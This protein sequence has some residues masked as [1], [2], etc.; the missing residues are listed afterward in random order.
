MNKKLVIVVS[1]DWFFLSHRLPLA[2]E[3][4]KRG[5]DVVVAAVEEGNKGE[6]IRNLGMTFYPLPTTRSG[7]TLW[8]EIR[9]MFYLLWVYL[10]ERPDIVHHVAMKPVT[11]GSIVA[12]ICGVK[13]V[14]NAL[15]GMGFLFI[16]KEKTTWIHRLLRLGFR[17]GF[18]NR[19]IHFI[20]QNEDDF[21]LV[22][23]IGVLDPKQLYMIKGSGVNLEKYPYSVEPPAEKLKILL[24][25]RMLWDKGVGEFVRAAEQL[26]P[27]YGHMAEFVLCGGYDEGYRLRIEEEELQKWHDQGKINWIGYQ[28]DMPHVLAQAHIVVLPSYRE[29]L[30]KSLIEACSIGRPIVTTDVPGCRAVVDDGVNGYL[31]PCRNRQLLAEAIEKLILD[32]NLRIRMGK[33]S[34]DKAEHLFSLTQVVDQTFTIYEEEDPQIKFAGLNPAI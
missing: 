24:P 5:Y 32:R 29:G 30:P 27:K 15:S 12:R 23:E 13:R 1:V 25:A 8:R 6:Q 33:A 19:N 9:V 14:V 4:M 2:E 34:R 11:Y 7:T 16:N 26:F 28:S 21:R 22:N 18:R 31:V 10:R 3:A 17:F 20:L